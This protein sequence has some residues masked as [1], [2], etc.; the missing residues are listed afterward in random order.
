MIF[1]F[2]INRNLVGRDNWEMLLAKGGVG[3]YMGV[4]TD[5]LQFYFGKF[6]FVGGLD[7]DCEGEW[8]GELDWLPVIGFQNRLILL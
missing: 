8:G 6:V 7:C 1:L 4:L 5:S 2:G 3:C